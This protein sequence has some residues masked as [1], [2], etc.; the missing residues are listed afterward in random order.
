LTELFSVT[1]PPEQVLSSTWRQTHSRFP[2]RT[3]TL[4]GR[5]WTKGKE[6]G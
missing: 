5:R 4:K 2:K 6:C 3:A 1:G